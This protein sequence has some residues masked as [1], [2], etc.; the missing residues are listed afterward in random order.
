MVYSTCSILQEENENIIENILKTGKVELVD[1]DFTGIEELPKLP[2]KVKGTLCVMPNEEYEGF[3][4][5][6]LRKKF[7]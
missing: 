5:A 4:V 3:F 7:N 2:T 1:I 6:K